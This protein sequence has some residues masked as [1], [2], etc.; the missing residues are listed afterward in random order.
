MAETIFQEGDRVRVSFRR[1][2]DFM[3]KTMSTTRRKVLER[4]SLEITHTIIGVELV[5]GVKNIKLD[6]YGEVLFEASL[7]NLITRKGK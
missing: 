6:G 5:G 4:L 7:F 2:A 3:D 1:Y